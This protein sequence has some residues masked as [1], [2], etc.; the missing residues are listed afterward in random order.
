M[1]PSTRLENKGWRIDYINV[2]SN[3]KEQIQEVKIFPEVKR[4]IIKS[5]GGNVWAIPS[6]LRLKEDV[7][8]YTVGLGAIRAVR[9]VRYRYNGRAGTVK[10]SPGIGI[11][12]QEMEKVM[13]ETV[14]VMGAGADEAGL[15][16]LRIYDG[17]AL[18]FALVNAVKELSDRIEVLEASLATRPPVVN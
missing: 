5:V 15:D 8:A 6:D 9:P 13:P 12:G 2:T 16:D 11:I 7:S 4:Q 10:G 1:R 18:V 14:S 3:L 17:S